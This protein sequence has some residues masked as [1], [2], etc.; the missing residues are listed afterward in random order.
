MY[1]P[2]A[3]PELAQGRRNQR[4]AGFRSGD[5]QSFT[6][7]CELVPFAEVFQLN[8]LANPVLPEQSPPLLPLAAKNTKLIYEW[9]LFAIPHCVL[10]LEL[11]ASNQ[12]HMEVGVRVICL[13]PMEA[14]EPV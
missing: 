13:S 4:K 1:L 11:I 10:N 14:I 5:Y 8:E 2:R 3:F 12:C 7:W 6:W 9:T